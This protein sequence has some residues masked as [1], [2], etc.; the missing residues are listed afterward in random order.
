MPDPAGRAGAA[1]AGRT[2]LATACACTEGRKPIF[3]K[4]PAAMPVFIG[5]RGV[6]RRDAE[7]RGVSSQPPGRRGAALWAKSQDRDRV[8]PEST[9]VALLRWALVEARAKATY[10]EI[11]PT[12]PWC[13]ELFER[14]ARGFAPAERFASGTARSRL[15]AVCN[16]AVSRVAVC[17]S[18]SR[19][20][21]PRASINRSSSKHHETQRHLTA[22]ARACRAFHGTTPFVPVLRS[23]HHQGRQRRSPSP[24]ANAA[25]DAHQI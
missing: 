9:R 13:L 12:N 19:Q 15:E 16:K 23:L 22:L 2:S 7:S 14:H 17:S 8:V 11:C 5:S 3:L 18:F 1:L 10:L 25:K 24:S 21:L 6:K 4:Q 20:P